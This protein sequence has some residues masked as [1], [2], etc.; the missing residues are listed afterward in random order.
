[1]TICYTVTLKISVMPRS[2]SPSH[3]LKKHY[4]WWLP[5]TI[6]KKETTPLDDRWVS[7][8][9]SPC[10][11]FWRLPLFPPGLL[12]IVSPSITCSSVSEWAL[13]VPTSRLYSAPA[14]SFPC[15]DTE[16]PMKL[17]FRILWNAISV[18]HAPWQLPL[19]T[20]PTLL[21]HLQRGTVLLGTKTSPFC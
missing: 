11:S 3:R 4:I 1:M 20:P 15:T 17:H 9:G 21:W 7:K 10:H 13:L 5:T 8:N 18:S 16:I 6:S 12:C 2:L 19:G 14:I